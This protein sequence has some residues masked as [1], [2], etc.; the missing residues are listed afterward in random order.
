[1]I[2]YCKAQIENQPSEFCAIQLW[3][4]RYRMTTPRHF[5]E[6]CCCFS[7]HVDEL[8]MNFCS[9]AV[10]T[11]NT[12]GHIQWRRWTGETTVFLCYVVSAAESDEMS[13]SPHL[14]VRGTICTLSLYL[15]YFFLCSYAVC[16][17]LFLRMPQCSWFRIG[18]NPGRLSSNATSFKTALKQ[19]VSAVRVTALEN[20]GE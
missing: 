2:V 8:R 20:N 5:A 13:Q 18:P 12:A 19:L 4:R 16:F 7:W 6:P 15:P 1:M 14:R 3:Q 11:Q 9:A 10:K 17:W